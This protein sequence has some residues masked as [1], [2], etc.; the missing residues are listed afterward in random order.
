MRNTSSATCRPVHSMLQIPA[1]IV[2]CPAV[3]LAVPTWLVRNDANTACPG[4]LVRNLNPEQLKAVLRDINLNYSELFWES[5]DGH[6]EG[7]P[8]THR[9]PGH[10]FGPAGQPHPPVLQSAAFPLLA[11]VP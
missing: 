9:R 4:S 3:S 2:I 7:D 8:T 6:R 10:A 11:I 1:G 5:T